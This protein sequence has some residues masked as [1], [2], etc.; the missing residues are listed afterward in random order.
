M[1]KSFVILI[2]INLSLT[3]YA[4]TLNIGVAL[5]LD[6]EDNLNLL[7]NDKA[8]TLVENL[9]NFDL[10]DID[11]TN[12][13]YIYKL[14][15][16]YLTTM[17]LDSYF[18]ELK[19]EILEETSEEELFENHSKY[20][21]TYSQAPNDFNLEKINESKEKLPSRDEI[22]NETESNDIK[23]SFK[24]LDRGALISLLV[25]NHNEAIIKNIFNKEEIDG[26]LLI[27]FPKINNVKTL[28]IEYVDKLKKETIFDKV[29]ATQF[30]NDLSDQLLL[31]FVNYFNPSYSILSITKDNNVQNIKEITNT[32]KKKLDLVEDENYNSVYLRESDLQNLNTNSEFFIAK[33]GVHYFVVSNSLKSKIVKI[34]LEE[35]I[36]TLALTLEQDIIENINLF[37]NVGNVSFSLNGIPLENGS[38]LFL[39]NKSLPFYIE[40]KKEGFDTLTIQNFS[41]LED[42]DFTLKPLWMSE[43]KIIDKEQENFYSSLFSFIM[44]TFGSLTIDNINTAL[45]NDTIEPVLDI[46]STSVVSIS[47]INIIY[48]LI[49]Y[50][51]IATT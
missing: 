35:G 4:A 9:Y 43:S 3:L 28:K 39:K 18:I 36:N 10:E 27:S 34:N 16:T 33:K 32:T 13:N 17:D 23:L 31:S 1:K 41:S 12:F 30:V 44:L 46:L 21:Q 49:S 47:S 45:D 7:N 2:L 25:E 40:A 42:I 5:A 50:L 24:E 11:T 38:A 8:S 14:C 19:N 20:L 22:N 6:S 48:K 29:L 15:T 51:K 26:L 37:S